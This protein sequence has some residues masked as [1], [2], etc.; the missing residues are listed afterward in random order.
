MC[1]C[2]NINSTSHKSPALGPAALQERWSGRPGDI[3]NRA[4]AA[5]F[6]PV[7][8]ARSVPRRPEEKQ[9]S[10]ESFPQRA[11]KARPE[12]G[13]AGGT[14]GPGTGPEPGPERVIRSGS[15]SLNPPAPG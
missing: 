3:N 15:R 11:G 12:P 8:M 9:K 10:S 2:I 6:A 13:A 5:L 14:A 1:S 7:T 4:V